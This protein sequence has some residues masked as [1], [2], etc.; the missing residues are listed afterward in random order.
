[1]TQ[2]W[3]NNDRSELYKRDREQALQQTLARTDRS[4]RRFV[5]GRPFMATFIAVGAGFLAGRLL[6]RR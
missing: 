2:E 4:L 1:M 3:K 5:R 6:S